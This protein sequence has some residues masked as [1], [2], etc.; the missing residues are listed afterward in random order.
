MNMAKNLMAGLSLAILVMILFNANQ[1]TAS[2]WPERRNS[3]NTSTFQYCNDSMQDCPIAEDENV[4]LLFESEIDSSFEAEV[5]FIA[6][7]P[8]VNCGR[9]RSYT[10]CLPDPRNSKIVERCGR[11]YIKRNRGCA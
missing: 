2:A 5:S 7:R 10:S 3:S 8:A 6:I 9:G 11:L 4:V 1:S